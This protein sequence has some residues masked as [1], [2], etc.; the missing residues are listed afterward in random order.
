M[1]I[2][3]EKATLLHE[4][5]NML[6]ITS[7]V[8]M[9]PIERCVAKGDQEGEATCRAALQ[10]VPAPETSDIHLIFNPEGLSD[11]E[12]KKLALLGS[13]EAVDK[14]QQAL[15]AHEKQLEEIKQRKTGRSALVGAQRKRINFIQELLAASSQ[16][17]Q[18]QQRG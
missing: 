14:L 13:P 4:G 7:K 15:E 18:G 3:G 12:L 16:Y 1:F 17:R 5:K 9:T 2:G 11:E 10:Q 6:P 8:P